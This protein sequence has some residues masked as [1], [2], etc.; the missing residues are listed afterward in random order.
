MGLFFGLTGFWALTSP[1]IGMLNMFL[2]VKDW[3]KYNWND[4]SCCKRF[5]RVT[6]FMIQVALMA[7]V[8]NILFV[9]NSP[10]SEL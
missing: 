7:Y 2:A 3:Q 9:Y 5:L 10:P 8:Y 1:A 6:L 4:T